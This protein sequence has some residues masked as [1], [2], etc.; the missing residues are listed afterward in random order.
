MNSSQNTRGSISF[1]FFGVPTVIH[2]SS[3]LVLLVLGSGVGQ[4]MT[5][6]PILIFTLIGM[7]SLL[8]HE[9]G[10]AFTGLA[11]G[12]GPCKVEIASMGG[13]TI[14]S[15]PPPTRL[16]RFATTLAGP[17][18]TFLLAVLGSLV[19]SVHLGV[20]AA[21]TL[22]FALT[23]PLPFNMPQDLL[24]WSY[25]PI[26][27]SIR[28][29][30]IGKF[31]IM[32]Y[33]LLFSVSVWWGLFNLMPIFPLDGGKLLYH[34]T[35]NMRL[36]GTVGV[37]VALALGVWGLTNGM[38]FTLLICAWFVWYNWQLIRISR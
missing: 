18:A 5:L 30:H 12:G 38:I 34:L 35:N 13:V 16:R 31:G 32:C 26:I 29:G 22:V 21:K 27:D 8:A 4:I 14:Y 28:A 25:L 11:L 20:P 10:H 9:Y 24:E 3:W 2:P 23:D 33:Q 17:A 19:M 7:I 1:T 37:A 36:V 15:Y 6:T